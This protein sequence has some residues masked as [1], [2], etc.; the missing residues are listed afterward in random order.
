MPIA[1]EMLHITPSERTVLEHLATGAPTQEI[2]RRVGLDQHEVDSCLQTLFTR[3]GVTTRAEAVAA[4]A[5]RG[6]LAA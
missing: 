1:T 5:R 6:L 3:M 2:A 4:A